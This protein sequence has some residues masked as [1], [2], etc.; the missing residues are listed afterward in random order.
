M[1]RTGNTVAAVE[2]TFG[3]LV[4][5]LGRELAQAGIDAPRAA[6]TSVRAFTLWY[7]EVVQLLEV[8][9]SRSDDRAG[10]TRDEVELMCRSA[11]S[12]GDLA[13]AMAL[14]ARFGHMLHPRAGRVEV[15]RRGGVAA[16]RLDSLRGASTTASSLVDITGLFAFR[17]LLQWLAGVELPLLQVN[18]GPVVREDVLP[19]LKLF[20][21]P[22]LCGGPHYVL[23]FPAEVLKLPV[24]RHAGEFDDF[25]AVFPCGVFEDTQ[26]SLP[27]QVASLLAAS[28]RQGAGLPGQPQLATSLGMSLSTLRRRL[29][30]AGAPYRRLREDCLREAACAWLAAGVPVKEVS[31]RLGFSDPGA[32]RRAFR[33]WVGCAPGEWG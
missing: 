12:A 14:C 31:A 27:E 21:A 7:L 23:E 33:G 1:A 3:P 19:F 6:P 8:Y 29:A 32:F 22:V 30:Q 4:E 16:L 5:L 24:V 25:F 13:Q 2:A 11:L 28:L 17:Q 18:I 26:R 20:R 10:M 9:C 15:T